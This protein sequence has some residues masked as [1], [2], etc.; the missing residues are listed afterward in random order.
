VRIVS[1][2]EGAFHRSP[3]RASN[4]CGL[5]I[6]VALASV[7]KARTALRFPMDFV[8]SSEPTRAF[9]PC[10][11]HGDVGRDSPSTSRE[12]KPARALYSCGPP[13]YGERW[14]LRDLDFLDTPRDL[15]P[16][17]ALRSYGAR[18][19]AALECLRNLDVAQSR[20]M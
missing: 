16:V 4:A 8:P 10:R 20:A 7:Q 11:I 17:R 15:Q 13:E 1:A 14:C 2:R 19:S 6:V 9:C 18:K 3:A 5:V 12:R